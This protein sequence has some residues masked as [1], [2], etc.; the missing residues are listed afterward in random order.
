MLIWGVSWCSL[1]D[2]VDFYQG[3]VHHPDFRSSA[4][5]ILIFRTFMVQHFWYLIAS[6]SYTYDWD[7]LFMWWYHCTSTSLGVPGAIFWRVLGVPWFLFPGLI[8]LLFW[9]LL[10]VDSD[11]FQWCLLGG[12]KSFYTT[13]SQCFLWRSLAHWISWRAA[14]PIQGA[15]RTRQV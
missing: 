7:S 8:V 13:L 4:L 12:F 14:C 9:R 15:H 3:V 1:P 2:C 10:S 11:C 5:G 6:F